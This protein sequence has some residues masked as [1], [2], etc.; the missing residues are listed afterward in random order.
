MVDRG[1]AHRRGIGSV[2]AE[3]SW[4]VARINWQNLPLQEETQEPFDLI[5]WLRQV[6]PTEAAERKVW[7]DTPQGRFK[8]R[9]ITRRLSKRATQAAQRRIRKE[10][11]KKGRTPDRRTITA[12]GFII[13]LTNLPKE[14][15]SAAEVLELYR[16]RWQVELTFK[17]LKGVLELNRLRSKDPTLAQVYLLGKLIAALMSD[18]LTGQIAVSCPEWFQSVDR[19]V[20]PWR[21]L[22]VL[23]DWIRDAVRGA[24]TLERIMASLGNLGRYLRDTPRK[25]PQQCAHA[26]ALLL[27]L[28]SG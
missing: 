6:S 18:E 11:R 2:L 5:A 9:L 1:Y 7:I 15:W 19:P 20:S 12:A 26:R 22:V 23:T 24:I 10:A 21:M 28:N 4:L 13:L 27:A 17:R 8:M 14:Q 3:G 16:I 25:R